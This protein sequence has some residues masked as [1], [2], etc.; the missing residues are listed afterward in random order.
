VP[1]TGAVCPRPQ[2]GSPPTLAAVQVPKGI[3]LREEQLAC[4]RPAQAEMKREGSTCGRTGRWFQMGFNVSIH[5][6]SHT[7]MISDPRK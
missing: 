7:E 2:P 6:A 5:S 4:E 1:A 3:D